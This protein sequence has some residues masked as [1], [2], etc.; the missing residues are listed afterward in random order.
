MNKD[1]YEKLT[2]TLQKTDKISQALSKIYKK[3]ER[4]IQNT[5][6]TILETFERYSIPKKNLDC[7]IQFH[8]DFIKYSEDLEKN[9]STINSYEK[10][11]EPNIKK[12]LGAVNA[13][14]SVKAHNNKIRKYQAINIVDAKIKKSEKSLEGVYDLIRKRFFV[15]IKSNFLNELEG[16]NKICNFLTTYGNKSEIIEGYIKIYTSKYCFEGEL[17]QTDSFIKRINDS[18]KLFTSIQKMNM[19][20]FETETYEFL[21]KNMIHLLKEDMKTNMMK[22][23]D[24]VDR[25]KNKNDIFALFAIYDTAKSHEI[26]VLKHL[27]SLFQQLFRYIGD[28]E[29]I[30]SDFCV[31]RFVTFTGRVVG[32]FTENLI[33]DYIDQYGKALKVKEQSAFEEKILQTLYTKIKDLAIN[34]NELNKNVYMLN[35]TSHLIK[36]RSNIGEKV[37]FDD[38]QDYKKDIVE[39]FRD[40]GLRCERNCTLFVNST[41]NCLLKMTIPSE[42]K[43]YIFENVK[44]V[45]RELYKKKKYDGNPEDVLS[46]LDN[47]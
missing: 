17:G 45:L 3:M 10:D 40:E 9:V 25:R 16:L 14:E 15:L 28:I 24:L 39:Y 34:E 7:A 20:L 2:E 29:N 13:Y 19:F 11:R 6:P 8:E 37:L 46:K 42:T 30:N 18:E 27:H 23:L 38:L 22:F 32:A 35:N 31:E 5:P 4:H 33:K 26:D 43:N 21:N 1:E 36:T 47:V 12:D 41:I 44:K